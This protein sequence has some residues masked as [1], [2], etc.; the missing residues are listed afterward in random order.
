MAN[1][2]SIFLVLFLTL[3]QVLSTFAYS[4]KQLLK[5]SSKTSNKIISLQDQKFEQ[6]LRGPRE[7][8]YILLLLTATSPNV[9]CANCLEFEPMF[10][11]MAASWFQDHPD[12]KTLDGTKNLF[13]AKADVK[14]T[15]NLPPIFTYYEI[16]HV[17]RIMLFTPNGSTKDFQSINFD[18]EGKEHVTRTIDAVQRYMEINEFAYHE[19]IDWASVIITSISAFVIIFVAKRHGDILLK[20]LKMRLLWGIGCVAFIILMLGGFMFNQIK[21]PQLA[22]VGKDGGILYFLER[23]TQNQFAIETQVL[24]VIYG[25][26]SI[27]VVGLTMGVPKIDYFYSKPDDAT[28][29]K[30]G[31]SIILAIAIYMVF[32]GLTN[33]F[34]M[35]NVG[36]PYPLR[37]LTQF[38][39]H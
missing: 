15:N 17:P 28:K 36:Y 5:A 6:I 32:T 22:G 18:G 37:S 20:V 19:P 31:V 35:K 9:N 12:G 30:A 29:V 39:F 13:F 7:N 8:S 11:N 33:I 34:K 16:T 23:E 14:D 1:C 26:F 24:G 27:L 2:K 10:A 3:F 38:L 25:L 4:D 21:H